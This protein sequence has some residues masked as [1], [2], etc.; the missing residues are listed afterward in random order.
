MDLKLLEI[1]TVAISMG[2]GGYAVVRLFEE[3]RNKPEGR[4]FD[5]RWCHLWPWGRISL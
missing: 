2:D 3:M 4:G 5:S 1:I